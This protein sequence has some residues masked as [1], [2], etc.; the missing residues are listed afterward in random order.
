V[1]DRVLDAEPLCKFL[2]SREEGVNISLPI[3]CQRMR[4]V[5]RRQFVLLKAVIEVWQ[6]G[7]EQ[8]LV[9]FAV[10]EQLS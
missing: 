3:G 6:H 9:E 5:F 8:L 7:G 10:R 1:E 4:G 2:G